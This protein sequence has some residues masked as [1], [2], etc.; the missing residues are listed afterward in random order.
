MTNTLSQNVA[1]WDTEFTKQYCF[2]P[3]DTFTDIYTN[4]PMIQMSCQ[5][6]EQCGGKGVRWGKVCGVCGGLLRVTLK[7]VPT[8]H[9]PGHWDITQLFHGKNV[10]V[11]SQ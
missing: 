1:T 3:I 9:S 5:N 10:T 2:G 6:R 4:I 11:T 8:S 7:R